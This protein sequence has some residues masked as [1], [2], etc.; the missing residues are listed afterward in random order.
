MGTD[1]NNDGDETD[2]AVDVVPIVWAQSFTGDASTA[3]AFN[4]DFVDLP[5]RARTF[6]DKT[7]WVGNTSARSEDAKV[8]ENPT[9]TVGT[10]PADCIAVATP[11]TG[12]EGN[13]PVWVLNA[14]GEA[15][16]LLSDG[17]YQ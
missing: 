12:D 2:T 4:P 5:R 16:A 8:I 10:A 9:F 1:V 14:D 13:C 15:V 7:S 3:K 17:L 6:I 11:A